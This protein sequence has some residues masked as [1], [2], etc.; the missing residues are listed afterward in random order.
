MP[1]NFMAEHL[2]PLPGIPAFHVGVTAFNPA[3][4][5]PI[6]LPTKASRKTV[7]EAKCLELCQPRGCLWIL[8][9][10]K[11]GCC[12]HLGNKIAGARSLSLCLPVSLPLLL[13]SFSLF[14]S[15][16]LSFFLSNK[17]FFFLLMYKKKKS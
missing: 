3:V 10:S 8:A 5:V 16:Y 11:P 7:D 9:R 13:C 15:P 12:S 17:G 2:K 14:L 6:Q 4:P 1:H